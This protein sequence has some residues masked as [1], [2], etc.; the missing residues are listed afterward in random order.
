MHHVGLG[1]GYT[2]TLAHTTQRDESV[3]SYGRAI[4]NIWY[5]YPLLSNLEC[6]AA[7]VIRIIFYLWF[8][9][10]WPLPTPFKKN[11]YQDV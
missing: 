2:L 4:L 3:C 11:Y 9:Y 8:L 10:T 6:A 7:E 5:S 1:F